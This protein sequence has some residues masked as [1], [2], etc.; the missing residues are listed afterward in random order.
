MTKSEVESNADIER[1]ALAALARLARGTHGLG[2]VALRLEEQCMQG[3]LTTACECPIARYL[4]WALQAERVEVG[5]CYIGIIKTGGLP[6]SIDT[7]KWVG[8]FILEFDQGL[9]PS[10][11]EGE[12]G[13][14]QRRTEPLPPDA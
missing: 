1:R 7:P 2:E 10:L 3:Q 12:S 4:L 8:A 14:D 5:H 9:Y 13:A 6:T 11:I